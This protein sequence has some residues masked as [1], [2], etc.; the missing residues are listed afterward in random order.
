[1]IQVTGPDWPSTQALQAALAQ[2][3]EVGQVRWGASPCDKLQ[4][5]SKLRAAG[6]PTPIT[7]TS[8]EEA[9]DWVRWGLPVWGRKVR[10]SQG[11]DI[12]KFNASAG[13]VVGGARWARR[14]FWVQVLPSTRE[15]R[16]HVWGSRAFRTGLKVAIGMDRALAQGPNPI[17]SDRNGWSLCYSN[18][19]LDQACPDRS[20]IRALAKQA[21]GALGVAG[22]AVDL[23]E[24]PR[25]ELTVLEV[26][27]APALGPNTLEA[28][29]E[30]IQRS[31]Q[32]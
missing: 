7:T 8:L 12:A 31:F 21:C 26:N 19:Q 9:I 30:A 23:L 14:D 27:T 3:P 4:A 29:V 15:W 24:G 28:Y 25:G 20:R 11:R 18:A 13:R 1:M 16:C 10:H 5:F 2:V 6:V 32:L 22:G 17:R